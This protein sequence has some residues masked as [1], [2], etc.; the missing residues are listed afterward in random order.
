M[1]KKPISAP[2]FDAT[3]RGQANGQYQNAT[4][5]VVQKYLDV[6]LTT[7]QAKP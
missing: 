5:H 4:K 7:H 1:G 3:H 6:L 2:N